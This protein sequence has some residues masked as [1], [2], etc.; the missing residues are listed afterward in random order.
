MKKVTVIY[1]LPLIASTALAA[2]T[3]C[4]TAS[5]ADYPT[6]ATGFDGTRELAWDNG[7]LSY[8]V[9]WYT[10]AGSWVGNDFYDLIPHKTGQRRIVRMRIFSSSEWPNEG[11]DGF[12]VALYS[13]EGWPNPRPGERLWPTAETGYFYKPSGRRGRVWVEVPIDWVTGRTSFVAAMEQVYNDPNC[14][15][16]AVDTNRKRLG[17]SWSYYNNQWYEYEETSDPYFN[18]MIRVVVEDMP[19]APAVAPASFGRI[20]ALYH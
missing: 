15:P 16:F 6:P 2:D 12:C 19:Y 7:K 20:K 3:N 5:V 11:W 18:L 13:F 1:L 10:G 14:D 9:V 4:V 17:H 8:L